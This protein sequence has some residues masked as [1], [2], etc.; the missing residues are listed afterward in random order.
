MSNLTALNEMRARAGKTKIDVAGLT[1]DMFKDNEK[2]LNRFFRFNGKDMTRF[3][4][5]KLTKE[6]YE[7]E[8]KFCDKVSESNMKFDTATDYFKKKMAMN[9]VSVWLDIPLNRL[10]FSSYPWDDDYFVYD[11]LILSAMYVDNKF[12]EEPEEKPTSRDLYIKMDAHQSALPKELYDELY[13]FC[14]EAVRQRKA[15]LYCKVEQCVSVL[16]MLIEYTNG[17]SMN[18]SGNMINT[19]RGYKKHFEQYFENEEIIQYMSNNTD[20]DV[21]CTD[22]NGCRDY[23]ETYASIIRSLTGLCE[24]YKSTDSIGFIVELIHNENDKYEPQIIDRVFRREVEF[25]SY[26]EDLS[27]ED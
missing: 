8:V 23:I 5:P 16:R 13:S 15:M 21:Y 11:D 17:F 18:T 4:I 1:R 10:D 9:S 3:H 2:V 20:L 6:E 26:I 27:E 14:I 7:L 19:L 24:E 25:I 22:R 12:M